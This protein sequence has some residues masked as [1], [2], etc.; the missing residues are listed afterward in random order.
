MQNVVEEFIKYLDKE[1]NFSDNTL[2]NYHRDLEKYQ[3]YLE[4]KNINFMFITRNEIRDYLI[5]LDGKNLKNSSISRMISCIRSFYNY[6]VDEKMVEQNLFK[7]VSNPKIEKKLPNY[8]GY[9]EMHKI[10]ES[11]DV[12]TDVG[13]RNRLIIEIF[14]ATGC[15]VSEL[16][17]IKITD[18]DRQA[19]TIRIMGKGNK[20]RIVYYGEYAR[21][22]LNQY[23]GNVRNKWVQNSSN[24]YLFLEKNGDALTIMGVEAIIRDI[25]KNLSL[26]AHVTPHTFRH[27][28]ATHLL[29]NGAD[30]KS[31]QELL[32]HSNLNTTGIYTHVSNERLRKVYLESFP[33]NKKEIKD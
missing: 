32:G 12:S 31:V 29:N 10:I 15:R 6:L 5:Y 23:L 11:I 13:L 28:F 17:G 19:L 22:V 7:T 3:K 16:V 9:E 14:Y 24:N 21:D 1:L 18:I 25:V 20:E 33:R 26:K 8:L 30:I 27:T 2:K 4:S